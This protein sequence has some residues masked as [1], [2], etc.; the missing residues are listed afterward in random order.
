MAQESSLSSDPSSLIEIEERDQ[1]NNLVATY[2]RTRKNKTDN[3]G[4]LDVIV[5]HLRFSRLGGADAR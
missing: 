4:R 1:A 5:G 2:V 3:S